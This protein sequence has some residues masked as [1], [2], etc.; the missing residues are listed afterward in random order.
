M[1]VAILSLAGIAT[2]ALVFEPNNVRARNITL[3]FADLPKDLDGLVIAHIS[4]LHL[5]RIGYRERRALRLIEEKS[6]DLVCL[7][8]DFVSR[9]G[10]MG[11]CLRFL[12]ELKAPLGVWAVQGNWDHH[13]GW[14]GDRLRE[15]FNQV[16]IGLLI[17]QAEPITVHEAKLW[18]AG[19]DDP[20]FELDRIPQALE[21]T[22]DGF[23]ILLIHSPEA[24][25]KVPETVSLVLSGHTHGG[26]VRL[27]LIGAP[28]ARSR[29][30]GYVLGLYRVNNTYLYVTSGLGTT[31]APVRF[32]CPPEVA[33]ITLRSA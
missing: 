18:I 4:D 2:Y 24:M 26:Q 19:S 5:H 13:T 10:D 22:G 29:G 33:F 8:G 6:P 3:Y 17:N 31:V 30:G 14:S 1:I 11:E 9:S 21:G 20:S 15:R 12:A 16:N 23:T 27:P 32:L 28:W 7:T 25:A